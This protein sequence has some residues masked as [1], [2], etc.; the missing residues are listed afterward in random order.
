MHWSTNRALAATAALLALGAL[1]AGD[2]Q[3]TVPAEDQVSPVQLATWIRERNATLR[4]IDVRDSASFREYQIPTADNV[5]AQAIDDTKFTQ[6][7][8]IVL[9]SLDEDPVREWAALKKRGVNAKSLSGGL[10]GWLSDIMQPSL[11][12][13]ASA[14]QTELYQKKKELAEYFGGQPSVYT[15]QSSLSPSTLQSLKRLKRR[16]C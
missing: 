1:F 15:E 10:G 7:Q 8:L 11:P 3:H 13:N 5:S 14:E 6:D 9:Y 16:T 4:I 2:V 12:P